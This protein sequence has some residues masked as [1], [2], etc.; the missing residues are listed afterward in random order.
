MKESE[1][2]EIPSRLLEKEHS[3]VAEVF[4]PKDETQKV[5]EVSWSGTENFTVTGYLQPVSLT[6]YKKLVFYFRSPAIIGGEATLK[7]VDGDGRGVSV[8]FTPRPPQSGRRL[9]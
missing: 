4:H 3:E 1:A 6:E 2:H 9:S 8:A 5:L 7:A